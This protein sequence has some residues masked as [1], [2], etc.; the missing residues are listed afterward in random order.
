MPKFK[1]KSTITV[2]F[3]DTVI[4]KDTAEAEAKAR[5]MIEDKLDGP[6]ISKLEIEKLKVKEIES[7][8]SV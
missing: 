7:G 6:K 2:K 4:A 8:T 5:R 1:V 3:K